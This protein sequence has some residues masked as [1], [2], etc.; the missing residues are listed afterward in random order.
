MMYLFGWCKPSVLLALLTKRMLWDISVPDAFPSP[1]IAF[2]CLGI[3]FVFVVISIHLPLM[4]VAVPSVRQFRTAGKG[5][6][7]FWFSWHLATSFTGIKKPSQVHIPWRLIHN[8][9]QY[10][11][12]LIYK[13]FH[14]IKISS[15]ILNST[16]TFHPWHP[17]VI[18]LI[19]NIPLHIGW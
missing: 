13:E 2:S 17:A 3:S 12:I 1:A 14:L 11:Y 18:I 4:H 9:S 5:A 7:P 19:G 16:I 6:R 15:G 10:H 8:F